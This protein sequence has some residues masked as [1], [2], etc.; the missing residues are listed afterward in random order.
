MNE[1]R[2][3]D[4][5]LR[6]ASCGEGFVFSCGEQELF[7]LRGITSEPAQCP[8]CAGGRIPATNGRIS[9]GRTFH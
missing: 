5:H 9:N 3:V 6:C 2:E 1:R 4:K 8:N 7:R